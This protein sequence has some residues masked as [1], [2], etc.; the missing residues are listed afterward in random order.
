M[1]RGYLHRPE[2]T[3]ERFVPDPFVLN[4]QRAGLES[5]A[6]RMYRTGDLVRYLPDGNVEFLGRVDQQVKIRGF[7]VELGEVEAVLEQCPGVREA[8]VAAREFAPGDR[9]LVAY[10]VAKNGETLTRADLA[11]WARQALP[12]YMVPALYVLLEALPLTPNAKIDRK[13]LPWPVGEQGEA[14]PALALAGEGAYAPPRDAEEELLAE[15]W[16]RV[17]GVE[18]VGRRD[19]FFDLGGHSLLATQLVS[20]VREAFAVELPLRALFDHP[21]VEGLAEE[22]DRQRGLGSRAGLSLQPAPR[23]AD[24]AGIVALPLSFAQQRLWFL[25]QLDPQGSFYNI[26]SALR[27]RGPLDHA[28]LE[29]SLNEMARRHEVLRTCFV[30]RDGTPVQAIAPLR[31]TPLPGRRSTSR[32]RTCRRSP[33]ASARPARWQLATAE[34]QQPFDLSRAPLLRARLLRLGEQDHVALFTLHHIIADGWS[35]TVF[36]R[37]I[38][39]LYA[40]RVQGAPAPL[41]PLPVQYADYAHGSAPGCRARCW[42]GN[43]TTGSSNWRTRPTCWT[44]P[45]TIPGPPC[46]PSAGRPSPAT[47]RPTWPAR[48]RPWAAPRAS[49]SL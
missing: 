46:R 14:A 43:W 2:L 24:E 20:R 26:P 38:T 9:R 22:I 36:T 13:A 17:L 35:M 33:K 28:A 47:Y 23:E 25:D 27:L 6:P 45:P 42:T 40:A 4:E 19:N 10:V 3:A 8:A 11:A 48:S 31:A 32:W 18:R 15:L 16:A 34:A 21:T 29:W 5:R 12:E 37:E 49:P 7:R 30:N 39:A 44:C 41:A 1:A